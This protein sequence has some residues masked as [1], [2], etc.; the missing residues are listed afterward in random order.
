MDLVARLRGDDR[1][2]RREHAERPPE[3][4]RRVVSLFAGDL[5]QLLG[6]NVLEG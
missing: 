3:R 6:R 2:P 5:E 4:H 1:D